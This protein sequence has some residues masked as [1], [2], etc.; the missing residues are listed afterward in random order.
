[1]L[2][3]RLRPERVVALALL[4]AL[5]ALRVI[6]PAPIEILRLKT[7][8]I[9]QQA[10]PRRP[11]AERPVVIVDIDEDS[12]KANGQW[13]WPRTLIARLVD[14][15]AEAKARAVAFDVLFAEADRLSGPSLAT[16]LAEADAETRER[17]MRLPSGET[18]LAAAMRGLPS[19]VGAS[20]YDKALG[21]TA[22]GKPGPI[23]RAGAEPEPFLYAYAG[24]LRTRPELE[25][26]SAG[27]G[28]INMRPERDGIVRRVPTVLM[29]EGQLLATLDLELLRVGHTAA[30]PI[31]VR[32]D[33]AGVSS[34]GVAGRY[35]QTD[36]DGQ[37]WVNFSAHDPGRFVR[38]DD[39][40]TGRV[41]AEQLAGKLALVG[42]SAVALFDLRTTP[43]D[44]LVPGVEIHAQVIENVLAGTLLSR[45]NTALAVELAVLAG[46]GILIIAL[47]PVLGAVTILVVGAAASAGLVAVGWGLYTRQLILLDLSYPLVASLA[48]YTV[49]T[50]FNYWREET[51]REQ[52]RGTFSRYVSPA[53][54]EILV[55]EP[56]RVKLGGE[57]REITV[58]FSDV[59]GFTAISEA[60]K[61][62]PQGLVAFMN[63]MLTPLT[64]AILD[65]NGTIDKYMGDAILAFWNAPLDDPD[66]AG[67]ACLAALD[68]M[69]RIATYNAARRAQA[70]AAGQPALPVEIGIGINTGLCVVGNFGT[71]TRFDYSALG[72]SVNIAS[73][74]EA[75]TK[76][77]GIGI[78]VGAETAAKAHRHVALL[79]VD[80]VRVK[81][82]TE[83]ETIFAVA[84]PATVATEAW[85]QGLRHALALLQAAYTAGDWTGARAALQSCRAADGRGVTGKLFDLYEER[86]AALSALPQA[87]PGWDGVYTLGSKEG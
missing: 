38:A 5:M 61:A 31:V 33:K 53:L 65:A 28:L 67:K 39:V 25:A 50:F 52:M 19:V 34:V 36:R 23:V 1:M 68:M 18:R 83:P 74:L 3:K 78:L 73:R 80:R 10:V 87:P 60:F 77:Y 7:F 22:G 70:E 59:R 44:R 27:I 81:G 35:L 76:A 37:I 6:D 51:Q 71:D 24:L 12:I 47:V 49:L 79:P 57:M 30:Q 63:G 13:P 55:R 48:V 62:D 54:V 84:G 85:Y 40:L 20:G 21:L 43:L 8:D 9:M 14:R 16:A 29:A 82:K 42:S 58:L 72:D 66:H 11:A 69:Q 4:A 45:P 86:L 2:S 32:A 15:L 41:G 46:L 17:L 56:D 64:N 75:I 26:A